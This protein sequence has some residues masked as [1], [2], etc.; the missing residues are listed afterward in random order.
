MLI[1]K[2]IPPSTHRVSAKHGGDLII[3]G[4]NSAETAN[5]RVGH[6][7]ECCVLSLQQLKHKGI[8]ATAKAVEERAEVTCGESSASIP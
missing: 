4:L 2:H 5:E 6:L 7:V 1:V 8:H 3:N